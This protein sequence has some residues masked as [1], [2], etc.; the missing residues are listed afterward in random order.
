MKLI[1]TRSGMA[2][3]FAIVACMALA[4]SGCGS[5]PEKQDSTAQQDDVAGENGDS[6]LVAHAEIYALYDKHLTDEKLSVR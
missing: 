6:V 3:H 2:A 4:S 1:R 5:S